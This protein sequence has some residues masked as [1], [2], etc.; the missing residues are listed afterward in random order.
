MT[1]RAMRTAGW[2]AMTSAFA[3]LPI[4]YLSW[5][6]D[7]RA[8]T[9]ATIMQTVIQLAGMLLFVAITLYL[10]KLLN[11][12][13]KFH[14]T[15]RNIDLMIK[16]NVT[17]GILAVSALYFTSFKGT[18][19]IA[20]IV[21]LVAQ[22]VIQAQFGYKLLKLQDNLGGMLKPFCYTN[23]ATGIMIASV[24]LLL[25]GAAVSAISDLMLGTIFFH[26]ARLVRA[27]PPLEAADE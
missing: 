23:M 6:L 10:K 5:K 19:G 9:T 26:V 12:Q 24:V 16:L 2:L 27:K 18:I 8:D 3:S 1:F 21:L 17:A 11:A 20:V 15:D 22:G 7:G 4:V 13:F 14:G 25:V